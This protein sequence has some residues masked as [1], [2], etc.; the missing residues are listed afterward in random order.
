VRVGNWGRTPISVSREIGVRPQFP[1][2]KME[3]TCGHQRL[4]VEFE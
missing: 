2:P 4:K 3:E 1:S